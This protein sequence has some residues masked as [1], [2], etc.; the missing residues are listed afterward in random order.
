M[1]PPSARIFAICSW[2]L[3]ARAGSQKKILSIDPVARYFAEA[4]GMEVPM[5][6][7]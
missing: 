3:P 7:T 6:Q 4:E 5:T 1:V 2:A